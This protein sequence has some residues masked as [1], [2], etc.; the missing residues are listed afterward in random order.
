[1][2]RL[3][4]LGVMSAKRARRGWASDVRLHDVVGVQQ[5]ITERDIA[6]MSGDG[7]RPWRSPDDLAP[8]LRSKCIPQVCSRWSSYNQIVDSRSTLASML[9]GLHRT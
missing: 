1:M 7:L 3:A 4:E 2:I 9:P 5:R 6:E 8:L